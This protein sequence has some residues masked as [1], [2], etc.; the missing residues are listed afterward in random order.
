MRK[1]CF[2]A[3]ITLRAPQDSVACRQ[4]SLRGGVELKVTSKRSAPTSRGRCLCNTDPPKHL[5]AQPS[6]PTGTDARAAHVWLAVLCWQP[7]EGPPPLSPWCNR[8][9]GPPCS[10]APT[11][12]PPRHAPHVQIL[13]HC[14][15]LCQSAARPL[16]LRQALPGALDAT[17]G[18]AGL[19]LRRFSWGSVCPHACLCMGVC[20]RVCVSVC[21]HVM[22]VCT[23]SYTGIHMHLCLCALVCV[24][25]RVCVCVRGQSLCLY[26]ARTKIFKHQLHDLHHKDY[27]TGF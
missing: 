3:I 16:Q 12:Y 25:M 11:S 14:K 10:S 21:T 15:G 4:P 27:L 17:G 18:A 24:F 19:A 5:G 7:G 2:G 9:C 26:C 8:V 20:T 22:C 1:P 6:P 23:Y 13:Q